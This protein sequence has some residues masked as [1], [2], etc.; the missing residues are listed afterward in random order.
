MAHPD[1]APAAGSGAAGRLRPPSLLY[2]NPAA[3][4]YR[5][6]SWIFWIVLLA[7]T[8]GIIGM[9]SDRLRVT[10]DPLTMLIAFGLVAAGTVH[11]E[12]GRARFPVRLWELPDGL[13]IETLGLFRPV[14]RFV[15]RERAALAYLTS[16][17]PRSNA[18]GLVEVRM[19]GERFA[20]RF[21]PRRGEIPF[22]AAHVRP[23]K[24]R[25]RR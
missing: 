18:R 10:D 5:F 19:P 12:L 17:D 2:R 22:G 21:D 16:A 11:A 25:R 6:R 15:P 13:V 3:L 20:Y 1:G 8:A 14:Q 4:T 23:D 24:R 9:V 7:V